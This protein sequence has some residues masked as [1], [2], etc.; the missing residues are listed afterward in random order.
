MG[1]QPQFPSSSTK[2]SEGIE[3][4]SFSPR[5]SL[6]GKEQKLSRWHGNVCGP[7]VLQAAHLLLWGALWVACLHFARVPL[8]M[9]FYLKG[10]LS[11]TSSTSMDRLWLCRMQ[12][13][14]MWEEIPEGQYWLFITY[15]KYLPCV[16]QYLGL[17]QILMTEVTRR[18]VWVKN[19]MLS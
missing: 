17:R 15:L 7:P 18:S 16:S 11:L 6:I 9:W 19:M 2:G 10:I 12:W 1:A 3:E 5:V 4:E 8:P 13:E 14:F